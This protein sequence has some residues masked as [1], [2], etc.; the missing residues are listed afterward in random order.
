[1]GTGDSV[2][3]SDSRFR[4]FLQQRRVAYVPGV[5]SGYT[6]LPY[7]GG[8]LAEELPRNAWKR[9]SAGQGRKGP[10]RYEWALHLMY[11]DE[12]GLGHWLLVR[13]QIG[14]WRE[15]AYYRV[16]APAQTTQ[17]QMVAVAGTR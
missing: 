3:G 2:Y 8:A 6:I 9:R 10:R 15:R 14:A 16:F 11:L 1:M 13:R 7:T 17:E 4:R 12:N 5:T